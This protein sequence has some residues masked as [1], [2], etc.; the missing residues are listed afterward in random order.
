MTVALWLAAFI[1]LIAA[2]VV[3]SGRGRA[4]PAGLVSRGVP[5]ALAFMLAALGATAPWIWGG[6]AA[7][8]GRADRLRAGVP[9][10]LSLASVSTV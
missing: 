5:V 1:I 2:A 6:T 7:I 10:R 8:A 3:L 4:S 9:V